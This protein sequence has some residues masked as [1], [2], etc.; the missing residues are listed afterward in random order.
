LT[1]YKRVNDDNG[2][3]ESAPF[4]CLTED[5]LLEHKVSAPHGIAFCPDGKR[6]A[7]V[8]KKYFKN[9]HAR[10]ESAL[11]VYHS[12][13]ADN[14]PFC[15][16]PASINYFGD[17]CLHSVTIHPTEPLLMTVAELNGAS[18]YHLDSERG[19]CLPIGA[20]GAEGRAPIKGG[21]FTPDGIYF[22]LT[23]EDSS[24]L[25]YQFPEIGP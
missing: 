5:K 9:K 2:R 17:I 4:F 12:P 16:T 13:E 19:A 22:A 21:A 14:E 1:F 20:I 8:H 11:V 3:Y 10:G 23:T 24:I 7:V 18:F 6:F 15:P 25:I